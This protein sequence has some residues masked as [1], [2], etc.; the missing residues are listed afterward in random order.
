[1][2]IID[3]RTA[4]MC[5]DRFNFPVPAKKAWSVCSMY[6]VVCINMYKFVFVQAL[7][8]ASAQRSS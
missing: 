5:P 2:R 6:V 8:C 3:A 4:T 1:M 7:I